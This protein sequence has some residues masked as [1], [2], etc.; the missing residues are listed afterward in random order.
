VD[1]SVESRCQQTPAGFSTNVTTASK[2]CGLKTVIVAC[3]ALLA[4]TNALPY[5]PAINVV[6]LPTTTAP[7]ELPKTGATKT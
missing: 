5:K 1:I 3:F 7:I 2:F 4:A 6:P